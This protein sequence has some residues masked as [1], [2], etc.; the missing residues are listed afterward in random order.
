MFEHV[1]AVAI[2]PGL[3]RDPTTMTLARR[4]VAECPRTVVV[5]A[6]A[7]TAVAEEPALLARARGPRVLTP[8]LGEMARLTG[9][10]TAELEATRIDAARPHAEAWRAIVVLKGAPTVVAGPDGRTLVSPP[11]NPG[12]ATAGMGDVLTGVTVALVAQGL[13]P[14]EAAG[15]AAYVH[16]ARSG[17]AGRSGR[18][19]DR[20]REPHRSADDEHAPG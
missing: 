16:G 3:S 9:V 6:D 12:M 14:F 5:D 11:G 10:S 15:L 19:R 1:D 20:T 2:G 8:H 4:V 17:A 18:E 13:K 7:L